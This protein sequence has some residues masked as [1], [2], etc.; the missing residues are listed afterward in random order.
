[1]SNETPTPEQMVL[2]VHSW[3]GNEVGR[4]VVTVKRSPKR[5]RIIGGLH[6]GDTFDRYGAPFSACLRDPTSAYR[7]RLEPKP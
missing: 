3:R 6:D 7:Y 4:H 2:I 1:M 5:I